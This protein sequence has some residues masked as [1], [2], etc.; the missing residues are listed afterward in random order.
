MFWVAFAFWAASFALSQT[1]AEKAA[2]DQLQDE[3]MKTLEELGIPTNSEIRNIPVGWGTFKVKSPQLLWFGNYRATANTEKV[4]VSM[5]NSK[6]VVV[7]YNY[8]LSFQLGLCKGPAALRKIWYGNTLVWEGYADS[9]TNISVPQYQATGGDFGTYHTPNTEPS[10]VVRFYPGT[11]DQPVDPYLAQFQDPCPA[12]RDLAYVV[13]DAYIGQDASL[14]GWSFELQANPNGLN[15]DEEISEALYAGTDAPDTELGPKAGYLAMKFVLSEKKRIDFF[16]IKARNTTPSG[17]FYWVDGSLKQLAFNKIIASGISGPDGS[18]IYWRE[19]GGFADWNSS[20]PNDWITIYTGGVELEAGTYYA[21]IGGVGATLMVNAK[22]GETDKHTYHWTG[23]A[24]VNQ[25]VLLEMEVHGWSESVGTSVLA[26]VNPMNLGFDVLTTYMKFSES[27]IDTDNFNDAATTLDSEGQGMG[28]LL[29]S[30]TKAIDILSTIEK[31]IDGHFYMDPVTGLWK[32]Q[33]VRD[34]YDLA[35]L[36]VIDSANILKIEHFSRTT[37]L[38]TFNV[39]RTFF[40]NRDNDYSDASVVAIDHANWQ[41]QGRKVPAEASSYPGCNTAQ[42]ATKLSWRDLKS[43]SI[44]FCSGIAMVKREAWPLH[45]GQ[46]IILDYPSLTSVVVRIVALQLGSESNE[47]IEVTFVQDVFT[48]GASTLVTP[49]TSWAQETVGLIAFSEYRIEEMP[50]ALLRRQ[51]NTDASQLITFAASTGRKETSYNILVDAVL[52]GSGSISPRGLL[53]AAVGPDDTTIEMTTDLP[54]SKFPSL[55]DAEIGQ[56]LTGLILIDDELMAVRS[57]TLTEYGLSL[58]VYRGMCDTATVKHDVDADIWVPTEGWGGLTTALT[59]ESTVDVQLVP[60]SANTELD[61]SLVTPVEVVLQDRDECPYPPTNLEL[62]DDLFPVDVDI[63]TGA[64]M[65]LKGVTADFLRRDFRIYDEVSQ[66]AVDAETLDP[67]FPANNDTKYRLKVLDGVTLLVQTG[68]QTSPSIWIGRTKILRYA[69]GYQPTLTFAV[70][71]QHTNDG[72][73]EALQDLS[74]EVDIVSEFSD[75]TWLG[76]LDTYQTSLEYEAPE[77]GTYTVDLEA[78]LDSDVFYKLNGGTWTSCV[79]AGNTSGSITGV[80][81]GDIIEIRHE[82]STT[83]DEEL[84]LTVTPPTSTEGAYGVF[85][86]TNEYWKV[87]G[88]GRGGFGTGPFGR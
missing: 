54:L 57:A 68:W 76:V 43:V 15:L 47:G 88:F 53:F 83:T 31:Q 5:F 19:F 70:G 74:H 48:G 38:G 32:I 72:T 14:Q 63:D 39:Q 7:G 6:N 50:Y 25:N 28:F 45:I 56:N 24:W 71:T 51:S 12:Y 16:R 9:I 41:I 62:N 26:D 10:G 85:I 11:D 86:F 37:W 66:L 3:K 73:K 52:N 4:D 81:I 75:D 13:I 65:A 82:D 27:D 20:E 67:T 1:M 80:T 49:S 17:G 29:Q 23:G 22:S 46:A 18:T 69:E 21:V 55:S 33:L 79:T 59:P 36:T 61:S 42:L 87:G 30:E 35:D 2:K 34:D 40:R 60:K 58:T 64:T 78:A 44:P 84:L 77:T 8:Y